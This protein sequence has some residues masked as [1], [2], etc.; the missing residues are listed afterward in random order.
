[1]KRFFTSILLVMFCLICGAQTLTGSLSSL[2]GE[3]KANFVIEYLTIR[4]MA[5]TD[6]ANYEKDWK[7]DKGEIVGKFLSNANEG[8]GET[9]LIGTF[10]T[11]KFTVKAEVLSVNEDGDYKCDLILIDN[12]TKTEV[13]RIKGI[14]ADGGHFGSTLNLIGD[15][16]EHTGRKFGKTLKKFLKK[17]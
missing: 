9:L 7:K 5:E 3:S 13:A 15:G 11:A 2:K 12:T 10:P 14:K 16:A 17:A 6:F 8:L 4:G 1:M